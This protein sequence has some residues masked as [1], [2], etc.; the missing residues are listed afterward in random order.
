MMA[1]SGSIRWIEEK[2]MTDMLRRTVTH[3]LLAIGS[4]LLW[5]V[6]ELLALQRSRLARAR[7]SAL[8]H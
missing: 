3:P 1:G 4:T 5:G 7:E 8:K 6:V 2:N